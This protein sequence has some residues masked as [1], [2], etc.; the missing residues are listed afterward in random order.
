MLLTDQNYLRF[1][2]GTP[3]GVSFHCVARTGEMKLRR[4]ENACIG[5]WS[6]LGKGKKLSFVSKS[7]VSV[8]LRVN[9]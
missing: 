4:M 1:L 6:Q 2:G 5:R 3:S 7:S 9:P 8:R